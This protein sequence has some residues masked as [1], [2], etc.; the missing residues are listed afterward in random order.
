MKRSFIV[1]C[2]LLGVLSSCTNAGCDGLI[3]NEIRVCLNH[4]NGQYALG[5]TVLIT[6]QMVGNYD[7][8]LE[9]T[10]FRF[11]QQG[12]TVPLGV[13]SRNCADTIFRITPKEPVA[14]F[15]ELRAQGETPV[16]LPSDVELSDDSFRIGFIVGAEKFTQGFCAPADLHMFWSDQVALMRRTPM[17]SKVSEVA[18]DE[19]SIECFDVEIAG[20]DGVPVRGYMAQPRDA[21]PESLPIVI[22]LR[23]AGVAGDW[24]RSHIWEAVSYAKRGAICFDFNAH[25]MKNGQSEEYYKELEEG[26]LKDY[27]YRPLVDKETFYF[28][29]MILRAVRGLDFAAQNPLWDGK[30]VLVMG[31]SQGGYQSSMLAGIDSRVS[32]VIVTVPAGVGLG[33]SLA[34]RSNSWPWVLESSSFSDY[35]IANA[36]Y[37]DASLLL[38]GCQA[39]C[40]VEI[41][42]VDTTCHPAEVFSGFNSVAGS[43]SY[44]TT[45]YRPH[46]IAKVADQYQPWWQENVYS[47]RERA[48]DAVLSGGR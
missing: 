3:R 33:G 26:I 40:L 13:I 28:K 47:V 31:E 41:G 39:N 21:A 23:A 10:V 11:G 16:Q 24:C 46:H 6:A 8:P 17:A 30:T 37:F 38:A 14:M 5:E 12:E 2:L 27:A 1:L 32:D 35:S 45:P 15:I 34:G 4:E 48:I 25:G 9:M 20:P 36:P 43:V 18:Q 29:N 42:L 19:A 44:L 22:F 7:K